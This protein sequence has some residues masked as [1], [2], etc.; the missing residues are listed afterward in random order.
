MIGSGR[1]DLPPWLYPPPEFEP[2]DKI[3]YVEINDPTVST[4]GVVV[5]SF[6]VP[7]NRNGVITTYGNNYIGNGFVEGS[8]NIYWQYRRNQNPIKFYE[9]VLASLGNTAQPTRHP[10]GF[11]IFENDIID[12]LVVNVSI[13][14]ANQVSGGRLMGWVYPKKYDDPRK[15]V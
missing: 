5:V 8:G 12:I 6:Q 1:V 4:D 2:V 9:K 15:W 10:A 7:P 11:R 3:G 13:P 14:F